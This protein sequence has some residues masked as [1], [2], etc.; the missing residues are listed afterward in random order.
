MNNAL[1]PEPI[2]PATA[3]A[4]ESDTRC[5]SFDP[6]I[7]HRTPNGT[8]A[9]YVYLYADGT[10]AFVVYR[11]EREGEKKSFLQFVS[12]DGK[13]LVAGGHPA[14]RPLFDL[15]TLMAKPVAP[16][17]VVEGEKAMQGAQ[18]YVPDGWIVTTWAGG[19][20][21]WSQTDWEPLSSRR[22]VIWPDNDDPGQY[23]ADG[24]AKRLNAYKAPNVIVLPP[25]TWPKGWDLADELPD[26][27]T[28]DRITKSL[29]NRLSECCLPETV[30]ELPPGR[31]TDEQVGIKRG[32]CHFVC[33]GHTE[34]IEKYVFLSE[35]SNSVI[36]IHRDKIFSENGLL[37]L[38]PD[39]LLWQETLKDDEWKEIGITEPDHSKEWR[40]I[41]TAL[42]RKCQELGEYTDAGLVRGPGIWLDRGRIIA[43][44]GRAVYVNGVSARPSA[45]ESRYVYPYT[46][47]L[48]SVEHVQPLSDAEGRKIVQIC[49]TL[50]WQKPISG[51]MLSGLIACAVV[52]GALKWR[53][54]GAINGPRGSGKSWVVN[55]FVAK[56]FGEFS[57]RVMGSSTEAG[58]RSQI[59]TS[60]LP[61]T[62]DEA[63]RGEKGE[64]RMDKVIELMRIASTNSGAGVAKG[65]A[66]H[67]GK[68]WK[69]N[70]SFIIAAIGIGNL[71]PAD[72]SRIAILTLRGGGETKTE[73]RADIQQHFAQLERLVADLPENLPA[74]LL[75]RMMAVV[76]VLIQNAETLRKVISNKYADARTGDQM[77]MLLAGSLAL[78]SNEVLTEKRADAK[79]AGIDW[80]AFNMEEDSREDVSMMNWLLSQQ[81]DVE[82]T[83]GG[84]KSQRTIGQIIA[85]ALELPDSRHDNL[86]KGRARRLLEM[87]GLKFRGYQGD[88][89]GFMIAKNHR[90]LNDRFMNSPYPG[91]Y[92]EIFCRHPGART[93]DSGERGVRFAGPRLDW[94]WLPATAF[95]GEDDDGGSD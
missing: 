70:S 6:A 72:L 31:L 34:E 1:V 90:W 18:R 58:I 54:H 45:I 27:V 67:K 63:E 25:S 37:N 42:A 87:Y 49:D 35:I 80:S 5:V 82:V 41:G 65:S 48:E 24:I 28:P 26:G 17:L 66:D 85:A 9:K 23:A 21:A 64:V 86:E 62:F 60:A 39:R 47:L 84:F 88:D 12:R 20:Q 3:A 78:T 69:I 68:V 8:V 59:E 44:Y 10:G 43:N 81:V 83:Q 19:A 56:C 4:V 57:V 22:V 76:P 36:K 7:K 89:H 32:A 14:P 61:V 71:K 79:L 74:R 75:R 95:F 46:R 51:T 50:R 40:A 94:V 16:V 29:N 55:N 33:L 93:R 73:S 77:G 92:F 52:A 2:A 91:S 38:L 15:P 11:V 53:P 30:A 13:T